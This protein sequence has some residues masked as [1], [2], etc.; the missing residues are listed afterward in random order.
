[1]NSFQ[2]KGILD[3]YCSVFYKNKGS[4]VLKRIIINGIS[5]LIVSIII[6]STTPID[7]AKSTIILILSI[8]IGL[9]FN[10]INNFS[11][12]IKSNHLS[13]NALERITRLD[14]IEETTNATFVT[15][16]LS[17]FNLGIILLLDIISDNKYLDNLIFK[18]INFNDIFKLILGVILLVGLYQVFLMLIFMLNRLK[19]LIKVDVEQE[20]RALTDTKKEEL[21]EWE[22]LD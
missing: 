15:I 16:V 7:K 14:L 6:V 1:M 17:I 2:I 8:L 5:P 11:D 22:S 3:T 13:Q 12:R 10:F 4:V 19:K 18:G 9:L 21:D 20:K